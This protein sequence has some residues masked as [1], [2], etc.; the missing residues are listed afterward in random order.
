MSII[1]TGA[2]GFI[3]S[4]LIRAFNRRGISD[5]IAIDHLVPPERFRR[6]VGLDIAHYLDKYDFIELVRAHKIRSN[7]IEAV[8]HLGVCSE[9]DGYDGA[10]LM[11]NNYQYPLDLLDWTQDEHIRFIYTTFHV[12][13]CAAERRL[14]EDIDAYSQWL[15]DHV[16]QRRMREGKANDAV[17]LSLPRIFGLGESHKYKHASAVLRYWREYRQ[18]GH[19]QPAV[20]P[21]DMTLMSI[22]EAVG[23]L[24]FVY[25]R[26]H[27]TGKIDCT[28]EQSLSFQALSD[29]IVAGAQQ[30]GGVAID[31]PEPISTEVSQ[32][33][34]HFGYSHTSTDT[35]QQVRDYVRILA[36]Q[37]EHD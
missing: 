21:C 11:D 22:E 13:C 17:A 36:G 31:P 30:D 14:P 35:L 19:I 16:A 4:H 27:L 23:M 12:A 15:F 20:S 2:A 32:H 24:L 10:Y 9:E 18:Y 34:S 1:I 6:L 33:I 29:A 8:F 7:D 28:P 26:P 3:G 5:I 25:E 37:T